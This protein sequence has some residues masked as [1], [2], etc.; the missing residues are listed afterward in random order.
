MT[1]IVAVMCRE[2]IWLLADRRLSRQQQPLR[3]DACKVMLL[4]TIDGLS[5]LGYAGLGATAMGTEPSTWMSNVLRGR[6]MPLEASLAVLANAVKEQFPRH[7]TSF[8]HDIIVPAFVDGEARLY[9]IGFNPIQKSVQFIRHQASYAG[10]VRPF[11]LVVGGSGGIPLLVEKRWARS[12]RRLVNAH[13]RGVLSAKAVADHLAKV[14]FDVHLAMADKSVGPRCIVV[15]RHST[16]GRFKGGGGHRFYT[17]TDCEAG[18]AVL[19]TITAGMDMSAILAVIGPATMKVFDDWHKD[20]SKPL[21]PP[22][23]S[24][25]DER[26]RKL[27]HGPDE[28]LR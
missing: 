24:Q 17:D 22:D 16:K 8:T 15:W 9:A 25:I 12:L 23:Q 28:K 10:F 11:D 21:A 4:E 26:V 2:T 13:V 6:N 18:A 3:D 14:N 20:R 27:P 1:L 7:V 19:P 5:I